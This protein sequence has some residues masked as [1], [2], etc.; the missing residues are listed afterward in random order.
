M[1]NVKKAFPDIDMFWTEGGPDWEGTTY[2]TEWTK[3]ADTF[4]GVLRNQS[5]AI[6]AWNYAL[7]EKGNPNIGPFKCAGLVT[8]HSK[9]REISHSGQFWAFHHFSGHI[10]RGAKIVESSG[11]TDVLHV[12]ARNPNGDFAA[13]LTNPSAEAKQVTLSVGASALKVDLPPDSV[14]TL[15]WS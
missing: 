3:W 5:R 15:A 6:I 1:M 8:I 13:V 4:T 14:T 7:D 10:K 12:V 9:T 11:R 2:A